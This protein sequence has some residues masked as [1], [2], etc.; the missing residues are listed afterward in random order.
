ME[1]YRNQFSMKHLYGALIIAK[2]VTDQKVV[3]APSCCYSASKWECGF[4]SED[5]AFYF[6]KGLMDK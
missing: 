1:A 6:Q 5:G 4:N 2:D 3:K